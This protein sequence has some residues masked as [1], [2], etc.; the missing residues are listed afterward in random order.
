MHSLGT[1]R[2]LPR[3]HAETTH[4][5]QNINCCDF[6]RR[7]F[8]LVFNTITSLHLLFVFTVFRPNPKGMSG[9]NLSVAGVMPKAKSLAAMMNTTG[10]VQ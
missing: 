6:A 2:D 3:T 7:T 9:V 8:L 4:F 5:Y 1:G 10:L